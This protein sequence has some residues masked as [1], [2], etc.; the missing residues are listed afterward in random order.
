MQQLQAAHQRRK[1]T[2]RG[3]ARG[4]KPQ[5]S[6]PA[7]STISCA[8]WCRSHHRARFRSL[9]RAALLA[10]GTVRS[11]GS[12][13]LWKGRPSPRSGTGAHKVPEIRT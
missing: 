3:L 4:G 9:S 12:L 8:G 10:A 11:S 13:A 7:G 5:S 2:G 1:H 6:T